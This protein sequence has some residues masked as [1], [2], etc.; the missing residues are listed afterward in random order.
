MP[1]RGRI[2]LLLSIVAAVVCLATGAAYLMLGSGSPPVGVWLGTLA[3]LGSSALGAVGLW[4]ERARGTP[5][6]IVLLVLAGLSGAYLAANVLALVVADRA[7]PLDAPE[8]L[9]WV[10]LVVAGVL[11]ADALAEAS[12]C[13]GRAGHTASRSA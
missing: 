13:F 8:A 3:I 9:H 6:L 7:A 4:Q 1:P 12:R 10:G 11:Y 2:T 5:R